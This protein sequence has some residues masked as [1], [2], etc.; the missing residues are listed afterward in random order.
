[1]RIFVTGASGVVGRRA[2]PLLVEAGHQVTAV[3]RSEVKRAAL[4]Q[5]GATAVDLDLFDS[6]SL[7]RCLAGHDAIINLAT[8]MPSS[9]F[10]M[11]LPWAWKE[12]D[13]IRRDASA[14]LVDA[15][16]AEG[17]QR[18]VQESF[19]PVYPDRGEAWTDETIP[20]APVS[21][22]KTI[23][24]AERSAERFT[25]AGRTGVVLRFAAFYGPD[26]FTLKDMSE[27][28]R[29]GWSPLAAPLDGFISSISHDDAAAAVVASLALP[30]G[31]YNVAD[32]EPVRKRD[33]VAI[34]AD[35]LRVEQ[36]KPM[37]GWTTRLMGSIGELLRRSE[38][39]SNAKLKAAAK[40]APRLRSV[41]DGLPI[42]LRALTERS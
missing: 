1:M 12:N 21:Y 37:P 25:R 26:A 13:R 39:L 27:M 20:L 38:R 36:P 28:V 14:I 3:G 9:T 35:T 22:N 30:A 16:I 2:V 24:D 15:A 29:R 33:Y 32:D 42:A 7:R 8:H 10:R 5:Q 41:R 18:F 31:A 40:W 11:T 23:L 34:I 4:R 6:R 17:V 19:A